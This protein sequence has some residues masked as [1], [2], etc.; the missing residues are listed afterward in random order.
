MQLFTNTNF[1]FMRLRK[2]AVVLSLVLILGSI[3]SLVVRGLNFGID[4]TGGTL[5]ELGYPQAVELS[6]VRQD[7]AEMGIIEI[8]VENRIVN[9]N[10]LAPPDAAAG[11]PFLVYRDDHPGRKR[12]DFHEFACPVTVGIPVFIQDKNIMGRMSGMPVAVI[13]IITAGHITAAL[14]AADTGRGIVLDRERENRM[15]DFTGKCGL[16][17]PV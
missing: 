13:V 6:E 14:L 3:G 11:R 12:K 1:D 10:I 2:A 5:L 7:L 8:P 9:P 17:F 16:Q 4:F 15:T